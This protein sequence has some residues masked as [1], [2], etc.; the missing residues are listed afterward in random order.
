MQGEPKNVTFS[1]HFD[2]QE[3]RDFLQKEETVYNA[4]GMQYE[5]TWNNYVQEVM[6]LWQQI[7]VIN[8]K[9]DAKFKELDADAEVQVRSTFADVEEWFKRSFNTDEANVVSLAAK[10]EKPTAN[11]DYVWYAGVAGTTLAVMLCASMYF[12]KKEEKAEKF[13]QVTE[14]IVTQLD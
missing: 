2:E 14:A 6:P 13:D 4:L 3:V 8:Q 9:Y 5:D 11:T 12:S 7:D 1:F 10:V